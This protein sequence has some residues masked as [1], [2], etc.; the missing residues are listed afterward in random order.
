MIEDYRKVVGNH[1]I[2][3]IYE[4]AEEIK[5]K[6]IVHINST[7]RGG[8]VAEIL[9]SLVPLMN[10]I[11]IDTGWRVLHGSNDFFSITK[12]FHNALQGSDINLSEMKKRIYIETNEIFSTYTHLEHHDCVIVHDPQPLPLIKFYRKNQPWIWRCHIDITNPNLK[13][14]NFLKGFICRYDRMIVSNESYKRDDISIKQEV[15]YPSIDPF[16]PKNMELSDSKISK[17][18]K[19]TG[20]DRDKPI[21][22]QVSRFDKWKDPLGVIKIFESIK[23]R[24]DVKLVL[25]GGMAHDDPEG[26]K[27]YDKIKKVVGGKD[28]I[29][30]I[31]DAN[32]ITVNALQRASAVVIQKSIREGFGLT[33]TEAMWKARVVV[34]SD[35]GGIPI[36]IQNGING[37]LLNP[38][39]I[40][41]FANIILK[42]LSNDKLASE[43]G[44]N[45][46]E[47]VRKRFLITRHILD[48][49]NILKEVLS[50]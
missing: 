27:I 31:T 14:W 21:I 44:R 29:I 48:Y 42:V 11:G 32:D 1:I 41:G 30:I 7:S 26:P 22:T 16:T 18:L 50:Q 2:D 4:K 46:K 34:A 35:V 24:T 13:L 8:G 25:C 15:I 49:L 37:F 17:L 10:D 39:D 38:R 36:Q 45:A 19:K 3:E 5:G 12:K 40:K 43:I 33:V 9:T 47:T 20:I 28:D 23:K 6:H